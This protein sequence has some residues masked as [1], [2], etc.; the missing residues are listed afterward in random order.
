MLGQGVELAGG[1]GPG[2]G[3]PGR[4]GTQHAQLHAQALGQAARADP[5]RV[6]TLDPHQHH[7]DVGRRHDQFRR[8]RRLDVLER[9]LQV[10]FFADG[11]DQGF[12]NQHVAI[13]Q[14][15][16]VQLPAEVLVQVEWR[17]ATFLAVFAFR[18]TAAA[19]GTVLIPTEFGSVVERI[20]FAE[21]FDFARLQIGWRL[22]GRIRA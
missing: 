12:A 11:L 8:Q 6:E 19:R 7:F 5:H 3:Q 2:Q 21:G 13:G 14:V 4:V 9:N 20:A 18:S 16:Q 10:A 1:D 22:L 15:A 17:S